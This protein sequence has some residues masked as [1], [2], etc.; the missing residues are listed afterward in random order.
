MLKEEGPGTAPRKASRMP[1]H[2]EDEVRNQPT[3][4]RCP[5]KQE[6]RHFLADFAVSRIPEVLGKPFP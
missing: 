3:C 1:I 2:A 6:N 4:E 5:G